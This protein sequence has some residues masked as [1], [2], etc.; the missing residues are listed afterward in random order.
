MT[1]II[2]Y[3]KCKREGVC[4]NLHLISIIFPYYNIID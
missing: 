2:E 3:N 1:E 4:G